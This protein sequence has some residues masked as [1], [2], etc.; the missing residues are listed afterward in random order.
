MRKATIAAGF[1]GFDSQGTSDQVFGPIFHRSA[2]IDDERDGVLHQLAGQFGTGPLAQVDID[3]GDVGH[4]DLVDRCERSFHRG[5]PADLETRCGNHLLEVH[6]D[7]DLVFSD[8]TY[9]GSGVHN[10]VLV[11]RVFSLVGAIQRHNALSETYK[12]GRAAGMTSK[13]RT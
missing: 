3:H 11:L 8:E 13:V 10:R 12:D 2:G 6:A 7:D 1:A 5:K 4:S 9:A